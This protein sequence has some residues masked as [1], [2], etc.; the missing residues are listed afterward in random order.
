MCSAFGLV[1]RHPA[2][3]SCG[4]RLCAQPL[5][6]CIDALHD[7]APC[8]ASGLD[9]CG[10]GTLWCLGITEAGCLHPGAMGSRTPPTVEA[11][12]K[13]PMGRPPGPGWKERARSSPG[14]QLIQLHLVRRWGVAPPRRWG[15]APPRPDCRGCHCAQP[16]GWCI[17]TLRSHLVVVV[18]VHSLCAGALTPCMMVHL[19]CLQGWTGAGHAPTV[20]VVI[21]LSLRAGALTPCGPILWWSSLC[22]AFVLVH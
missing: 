8:L 20:V 3:P 11:R 4:G 17:D 2:V 22:T 18:F 21:V 1:H 13:R 16:S 6:W 10:A 14:V 19:A 5:C 9:R 15:G 12:Q 7:G